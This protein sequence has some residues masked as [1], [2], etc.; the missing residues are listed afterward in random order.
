MDTIL[1]MQKAIALA[2]STNR[3][4]TALANG[5]SLEEAMHFSNHNFQILTWLLRKKSW[6][7]SL[8]FPL[9]QPSL[10]WNWDINH[11]LHEGSGICEIVLDA[12]IFCNQC[13]AHGLGQ[14]SFRPVAGDAMSFRWQTWQTTCQTI[15]NSQVFTK[16]W[17]IF[18][19]FSSHNGNP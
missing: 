17:W 18:S 8:T 16:L 6:G 7:L 14:G 2:S 10:V 12:T 4:K 3:K 11:E 5:T 9:C 13:F 19:R 1:H 15:Q